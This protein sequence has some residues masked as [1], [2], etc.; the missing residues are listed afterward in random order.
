[1]RPPSS[2]I[3]PPSVNS[4]VTINGVISASAPDIV[5]SPATQTPLV[6]PLIDTV[7]VTYSTAHADAGPV[8][9]MTV[10]DPLIDLAV[11]SI[12]FPGQLPGS[13]AG[14]PQN[15]VVRRT[16]AASRSITPP[17]VNGQA[18]VVNFAL[19][20]RLS[21]RAADPRLGRGVA[22]HRNDASMRPSMITEP[23]LL[24]PVT[25]TAP[26]GFSFDPD[27]RSSTVGG[28]AADHSVDRGRR[29][30]GYVYPDSRGRPASPRST[31]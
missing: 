14:D 5:F 15:I 22:E 31:V 28:N 12:I 10:T 6:T 20:R 24:Q 8:V 7:D 27:R 4:P 21:A 23:A 30:L 18:T 29:K 11:D 2:F 13:R 26:A 17:N 19:P 16:A 3:P 25:L 9:T 1:M